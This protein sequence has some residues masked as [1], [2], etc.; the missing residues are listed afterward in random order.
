MTKHTKKTKKELSTSELQDRLIYILHSIV[1]DFFYHETDRHKVMLLH[2]KIN[3][4]VGYP[5][6]L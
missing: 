5:I 1:D 6:D 2:M 4:I 3:D